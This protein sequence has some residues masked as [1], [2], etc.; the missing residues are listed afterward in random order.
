MNNYFN[1]LFVNVKYLRK[2]VKMTL[3]MKQIPLLDIIL[4]KKKYLFCFGNKLAGMIWS[5]LDTQY[6]NKCQIFF[7]CFFQS[8]YSPSFMYGHF[9]V[10]SMSLQYLNY[11]DFIYKT[12][13]ITDFI[14]SS[15]KSCLLIKPKKTQN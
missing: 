6:S 5:D 1:F 14:N 7:E 4:I 2:H 13:R 10:C 15:Y 11:F 12:I 3:K 8:T 9:Y